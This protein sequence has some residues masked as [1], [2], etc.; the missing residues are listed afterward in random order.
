METASQP[1]Q[2]SLRA[3]PEERNLGW[4]RT[5]HGVD[6]AYFRKRINGKDTWERLG[7]LDPRRARAI[8]RER[9]RE[10]G[11]A[12]LLRR[13]GQ[14][15][16]VRDISKVKELFTAYEN[17]FAGTDN[18]ES[19]LTK[20]KNSFLL[21]LDR[22][23]DAGEESSL[24]TF[25][26]ETLLAYEA[27]TI[28]AVKTAAQ[29]GQWT[30]EALDKKLASTRRTIAAT[31]RQARSIFAADAI[32]SEHYRDLTLPDLDDIMALRIGD[33][34]PLAY[35]R[36][37]ASIVE[38]V[39]AGIQKLRETN[40]G[41]W[42]AAMIEIVTGARRGTLAHARWDWFVDRGVIELETGR[43]IVTFEIRVAKGGESDV[44][45]YY[46]DYQQLIAA[47]VGTSDYIIPGKT[48]EER[49]EVLLA[50]VP[51]LRGL[52]LDRRQPNHELRKLF[53]DTKRKAHG[54]E[55]TTGALGHS[56][57]KLLVSYTESGPRRAVSLLDVLDPHRA[58]KEK[59]D[60]DKQLRNQIAA[61]ASK[62]GA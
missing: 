38:A 51:F 32:R 57:P 59:L 50:L 30:R 1:K 23:A 15:A 36:P 3:D 21:I 53:A 8:I 5:K 55:E 4:R 58:I 41:M 24:S 28:K 26:V 7:E 42:L 34:N 2:S 20:N 62:S 18:D 52:G 10:L 22:G 16:E 61:L 19:T 45:I 25:T 60:A 49:T 46:E 14:A 9:R 27:A 35:R 31:A 11:E 12:E 40:T 44:P 47:R 17:Y 13:L 54:A 6:I 43:R 33:S 39:V 48:E 37:A 56:D 29:K